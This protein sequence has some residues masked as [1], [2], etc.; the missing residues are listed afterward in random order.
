MCMFVN[1]WI[2]YEFFNIYVC[3]G[4][5]VELILCVMVESKLEVVY[6]IE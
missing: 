3:D 2:L 6:F 4:F 5:I 1:V